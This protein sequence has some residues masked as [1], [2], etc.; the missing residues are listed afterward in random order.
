V[1]PTWIF[2]GHSTG[3]GL[4]DARHA[5]VAQDRALGLNR[6]AVW[7]SDTRV[8]DQ[9]AETIRDGERQMRFY[10]SQ[11]WVIMPNH[12]HLLILPKVALSKITHWI[13]G[14]TA[15]EANHLL[16]RAGVPFWQHESYDVSV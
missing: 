8:A 4:C 14:R 1:A 13:K 9:A 5:F 10:E 2:A 15:R 6:G 3:R 7:L 12:V 11:A 16:G